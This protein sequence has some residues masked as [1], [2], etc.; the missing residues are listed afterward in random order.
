MSTYLLTWK[1]QRF[2]NEGLTE[3]A[4]RL[5]G[6][7]RVKEWRWSTGNNKRIE[8]GERVFLLRQGHSFPGIV[9]SGWVTRGS[10]Q[11]PSWKPTKRKTKRKRG[12]QAWYVM[13]NWEDMVLPP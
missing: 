11:A 3:V 12:A 8:V 1:P 13:V 6:G 2:P 7:Q 5:N 9:G 4:T 10:F